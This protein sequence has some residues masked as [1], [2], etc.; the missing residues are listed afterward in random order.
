MILQDYLFSNEEIFFPA[1]D[2]TDWFNLWESSIA[3]VIG[4]SLEKLSTIPDN[5]INM[6]ITSPPYWNQRKYESDG[7]GLESD[8]DSYMENLLNVFKEIKR[9]LTPD[10]SFWLNIG[11]TYNKKCLMGIPW[12]IA[13]KMIDSQGWILRNDVV[14]SKLKGGG[15]SKDRLRNTHEMLFHFVKQPKYFYDGNAIRSKPRSAKIID[16]AVVSAT[17]VSGIRYRRRISLSAELSAEE[18]KTANAALDD[19]LDSVAR[20]DISDFRMVIR[21]A[22]QRVTHSDQTKISGRAKELKEKGFYFLKYSPYG[23]MP[24]DVWEIIPEDTQKRNV[25]HYAAYPVELCLNPIAATCPEGGVVLDPFAGTGTTLVAARRLNRRGIGIDIS[26]KY[27]EL[28]AE[29]ILNE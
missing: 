10:G 29:R 14:W 1:E 2:C 20:G 24:S 21:G 17:G 6:V 15:S 28:S 7:I 27:I 5:S 3:L 11:D 22:G 19:I 16:G 13:L 9:V 12:R 4:N 26:P 25:I 8:F 23:S 18:K